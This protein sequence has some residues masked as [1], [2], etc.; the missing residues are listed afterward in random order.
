MYALIWRLLPGSTLL[1]SL[2]SVLLALLV[3]F[4]L[5]TW[6]FPAIEPHLP[7]DQVVVG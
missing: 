6:V 5:M 1:K 4:V 2:Q 3:L 7:I